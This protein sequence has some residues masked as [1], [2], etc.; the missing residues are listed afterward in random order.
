MKIIF[1]GTSQ[2]AVPSLKK[3]MESKHELLAVV[4]QPDRKKGRHLKLASPPVKRELRGESITIHQLQKVSDPD[5]ISIL[6]RYDADIFVV[7]AFGQILTKDVLKVPKKFCVNLH[8]SLLPKYRGAAPV[9]YAVINGDKRSGVTTIKMDEKM[10]EGE[11]ILKRAADILDT[12]TSE[13]LNEKLSQIGAEVLIETIDLI[14]KGKARFI[15]Q[16]VAEAT[17]AHKLKKEDGLIDWSRDACV[18]H[19]KIRGLVPWPGAYTH[20]GDK[21]IKIWK[22]DF[23]K[24]RTEKVNI[25]SIVKLINE[26]IVVGTG[27]G[28]LTIE[29]LQL[30]GGKRLK[31]GEFLRGHKLKVGD[32]FQ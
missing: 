30:E 25:G 9:N 29:M 15:R 31:S 4:T 20:L 32:K 28:E 2:F 7:A 8:A 13:T 12:D 17:Y 27:K 21:L 6:K 23:N 14:E 19:N 18:I 24:S 16:K 10:D 26:G 1:F 11:I 22:S 5:M 3:I